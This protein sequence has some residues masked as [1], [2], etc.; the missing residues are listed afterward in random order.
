MVSKTGPYL[1][2]A[3]LCERV[4]EEKDG[5]LSAIRI[6]DR[7][8]HTAMGP[9]TPAT[10][11]PLT[12]AMTTLIILKSGGARGTV[13]VR[14]EMEE[15]S[16]ITTAGPSMTALMEG[17]DRGQNLIMA[18]Q[19]TFKETGLYWFNVYVDDQLVTK[20]PFRVVYTRIGGPSPRQ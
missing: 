17:E 16:G 2:A 9:A 13:Q 6:I 12:Y 11:A 19:M 15:P 5:V 14:I 10:M 7:L 1:Q 18:M 3:L 20:M 4:M 8:I